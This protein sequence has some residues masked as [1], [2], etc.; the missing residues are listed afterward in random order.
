MSGAAM[1]EIWLLTGSQ[2]LR[3]NEAAFRLAR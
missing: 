3:W 1:P 2:E